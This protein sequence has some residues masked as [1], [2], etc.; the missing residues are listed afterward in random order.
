METKKCTKCG[1]IKLLL[2]FNREKRTKD[3]RRSCCKQCDALRTRQYY[4][5]NKKNVAIAKKRYY[6]LNR[7]NKSVYNKKYREDNRDTLDSYLKR[8]RE[9]NSDK[10]NSYAANRRAVKLQATPLWFDQDA[11]SEFYTI[12]KMYQVYTGSEYHVDHIVPLNSD[13]V[14]GLHC[15]SNLQVLPASDNLSKGNRHWPDMW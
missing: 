12:A 5:V 6:D 11:I 4:V 8:Y 14:C 3:G 10:M 13:V 2:E 15:D 1:S 9:L 7:E